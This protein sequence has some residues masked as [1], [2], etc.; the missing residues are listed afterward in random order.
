MGGISVDVAGK[1]IF[2][3]HEHLLLRDTILRAHGRVELLM[4]GSL[5][6]ADNGL[7]ICVVWDPV[8]T[9]KFQTQ[10]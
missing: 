8:D 3:L 9:S 2:D 5:S 1:E 10:I 4:L 6:R 7:R